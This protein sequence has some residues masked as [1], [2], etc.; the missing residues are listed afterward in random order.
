MSTRNSRAR[1][2]ELTEKL[3]DKQRA[4]AVD[5]GTVKMATIA[6]K[7]DKAKQT[8]GNNKA[9]Q[10]RKNSDLIEAIPNQSNNNIFPEVEINSITGRQT[11]A[12]KKV[13]QT[14]T[15]N[16]PKCMKSVKDKRTNIMKDKANK[17]MEE[18][19]PPIDKD[20]IEQFDQVD[21]E[22]EDMNPDNVVLGLMMVKIGIS[23]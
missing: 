1:K 3:T 8:V 15:F 10:K 14:D 12:K 4:A 5:G 21:Q 17:T 23:F 6:G 19:I 13:I 2:R 18:V 11:F 16:A 7:N 20:L 9:T 22:F